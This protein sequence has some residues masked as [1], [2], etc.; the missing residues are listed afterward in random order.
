MDSATM[1]EVLQKRSHN[2]KRNVLKQLLRKTFTINP[3]R[4]HTDRILSRY[5]HE[6]KGFGAM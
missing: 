6:Y 2:Q 5:S 1:A 3:V 4:A